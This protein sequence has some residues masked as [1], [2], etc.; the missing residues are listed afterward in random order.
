LT[1]LWE[2]TGLS[3]TPSWILEGPTSKGRG[4]GE[5]RGRKGRVKGEG[6]TGRQKGEGKGDKAPQLRFLATPLSVCVLERAG[7]A[8]NF[9]VDRING[10][11]SSYV[12]CIIQKSGMLPIG[13]Y[14][15]YADRVMMYKGLNYRWADGSTKTPINSPQCQPHNNFCN[16]PRTFT[17]CLNV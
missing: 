5:D 3:Q 15:F 13:V 2:L 1:P 9:S 14:D 10:R 7:L 12:L 16:L 4:E 17:Y 6:K 8:G 11:T